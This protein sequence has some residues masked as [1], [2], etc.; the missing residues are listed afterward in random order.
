MQSALRAMGFEA[1]VFKP[2]NEDLFLASLKACIRA[3][4]A[5][6]LLVRIEDGDLHAV[7]VAGM[8]E[9]D[10]DD[11]AHQIGRGS[12]T[13][14]VR[15]L[16][17]L[18]LHDDRFGPYARADLTRESRGDARHLV[19]RF[20]PQHDGFEE[21]KK[22]ALIQTAIVPLYAKI[23]LRPEDLIELAAELVP[24]VAQLSKTKTIG[25]RL[26]PSFQLGGRYL[27]TLGT[28]LDSS[29]IRLATI[30]CNA[31]LSRYV[32]VARFFAQQQWL[33]DFVFDTTDLNRGL[34]DV[35][36]LLVTGPDR[37]LGGLRHAFGAESV[38]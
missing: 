12:Q 26:E 23:R 18:Y 38:S 15:K 37:V 25:L 7:T 11:G 16:T 24:S 20:D 27:A 10:T 32:G 9:A 35:P 19:V 33:A 13:A 22:P 1:S 8:R 4:M 2:T 29:P 3:G 21:F 31:H 14:S 28:L 17:R 5:P 6:I 30:R 34:S 36:R